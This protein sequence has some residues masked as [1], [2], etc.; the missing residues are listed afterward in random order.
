M[1]GQIIILNGAPRA[2]KSSIAIEIQNNFSGTWMNLGVDNVVKSMT[3]EN[4]LPG[5]GLRPGGER[6]D[7]EPFVLQ[8]YRALFASISAHAKQGLNVVVDVGLHEDYSQHLGIISNC[9]Q[10][11]KD[12]PVLVVSVQC[13]LD[14]IMARRRNSEAL[15]VS[16][17]EGEE[18][19]TPVV[20]WQKAVHKHLVSDLSVDTTD[21][22]PEQCAGI[23]QNCL[24]SAKPL[25]AAAA[26]IAQT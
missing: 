2:G 14:V 6:P 16:N 12:L 11:L 10:L 23:I 24:S 25:T 15:Y 4:M 21:Q 9:F 19:P 5:I 3:P 26:N 22:T 20:R 17:A 1:V 7:L 18:V 13:S 8:S